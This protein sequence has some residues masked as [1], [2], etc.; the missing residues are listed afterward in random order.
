MSARRKN[1]YEVLGLPSRAD[2]DQVREMFRRLAKI[3]HPD[4]NG[5]N[6]V[7][8]M[9]IC[10]AYRLIRADAVPAGKQQRSASRA[11]GADVYR[12]IELTL[13]EVARGKT[14][15]LNFQ[16]RKPCPD[17]RPRP[18]DDCRVCRGT[19]RVFRP[20]D[21]PPVAAECPDCARFRPAGG[22]CT[23]CEGT[24]LLNRPDRAVVRIPP[25]VPEKITL[26]LPGQ[27]HFPP[28]PGLLP[29]DLLL[30][31]SSR[32]HRLFQ[33]RGTDIHLWWD[34]STWPSGRPTRVPTL[35]GDIRL[36]TIPRPGQTVRLTGLGLPGLGTD[37]AGD[38]LVHY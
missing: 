34:S 14:V 15:T 23:K 24:G 3:H 29:G 25:G 6:G 18:A 5:G 22:I 28:A 37:R 1:A 16:R 10:E 31:V 12:Q 19:G 17:C 21:G 8:F 2:P 7:R 20:G 30:T 26:R 32:P 11:R 27:G 36:K 35:N 38:L 9:E 33:R 13:E 4:R